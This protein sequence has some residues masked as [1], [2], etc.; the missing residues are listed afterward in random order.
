MKNPQISKK[1]QLASTFNKNYEIN[2]PELTDSPISLESLT[3]MKGSS[4]GRSGEKCTRDTHISIKESRKIG[5]TQKA[6]ICKD[7]HDFAWKTKSVYLV[8]LKRSL[9]LRA[10]PELYLNLN[11]SFSK[12]ASYLR[13][14]EDSIIDK[15]ANLDTKNK[16]LTD[17]E[18]VLA[19]HAEYIPQ[20]LEPA[21]KLCKEA[22][23]GYPCPRIEADSDIL[24]NFETNSMTSHTTNN[25]FLGHQQFKS[26]LR[27]SPKITK[28]AQKQVSFKELPVYSNQTIS[29]L[30]ES[31]ELN[32]KN[33]PAFPEKL[34]QKHIQE[35]IYHKRSH[36]QPDPSTPFPRAALPPPNHPH[37]Q[38]DATHIHTDKYA[39]IS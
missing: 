15:P 14:H 1:Q 27:N 25:S 31:K 32:T 36:E 8:K 3:R 35:Y 12:S 6:L 30:D 23:D 20:E 26:A 38:V 11:T 21:F 22:M 10:E 2:H 24:G 33:N 16:A 9:R 39:R 34:S 5:N 19:N 13:D 28:G 18:D 7:K 4:P 29:D 37:T 17:T